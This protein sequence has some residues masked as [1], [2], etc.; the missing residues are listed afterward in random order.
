MKREFLKELGLEDDVISKI[1]KEHGKTIQK[2]DDTIETYRGKISE[3]QTDIATKSKD[4]EEL[5]KEHMLS[6]AKIE[7]F[8]KV[9]IDGLKNS[10]QE[11]EN[12]YNQREYDLSVD[13][14]MQNYKFTSELAKEATI[15]KF[16]EQK[17]KLKDGK[18]DGAEDY[19]KKFME[20]NKSAF[21]IEDN[22]TQNNNNNLLN[23]NSM[24]NTSTYSYN[25]ASG[26]NTDDLQ[27][28]EG[29]LD[30]LSK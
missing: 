1:M 16:K 20:E 7:E 11:W 19:M 14:Y 28:F 24:A 8:E 2:M 4:Y 29:M 30:S 9:D 18:L 13:K 27:A 26:T 5:N 12:K 15:S 6:K 17:F 25:P 21:V 23:N 10:I 3:L 22:N